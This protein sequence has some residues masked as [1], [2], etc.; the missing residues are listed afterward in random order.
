MECNTHLSIF[1]SLT[2]CIFIISMISC[3]SAQKAVNAT[4]DNKPAYKCSKEAL[5]KM[6]GGKD[7]C[8]TLLFLPNNTKITAPNWT[9]KDLTLRDGQRISIDYKVIENETS[10]CLWKPLVA[11]I[12]CYQLIK[13]NIIDSSMLTC[14]KI[15]DPFKSQW[16]KDEIMSTN[17]FTIGRS[18][19]NGKVWFKFTNVHKNRYFDCDGKFICETSNR[20]Y[21]DCSKK[22]TAY[23]PFEVF[24]VRNN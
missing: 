4:G 5:V 8:G 23:E 24:W 7:S 21:G 11:K 6:F 20:E 2:F 22:V 19:K 10:N 18:I 16:M 13:D 12:T 1:K 9:P 14:D 3:K 17:P 15:I